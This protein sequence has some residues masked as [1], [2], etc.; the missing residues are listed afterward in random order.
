[1][2]LGATGG[3]VFD[4]YSATDYKFAAIMAGSNKVVIGHVTATG[5]IIDALVAKTIA[6]GT[7]YLFGISL[8]GSTVSMTLNGADALSYSYFSLLNDGKV[9]LLDQSGSTTFD[10][11]KI[12]GDDPAYLNQVLP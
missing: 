1:M 10:N 5:T 3:L 12:S 7:T 2:V 6:A 11:V 8:S 4:Y 9:G